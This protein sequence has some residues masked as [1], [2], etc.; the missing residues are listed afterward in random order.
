MDITD[1]VL[2]PEVPDTT[3]ATAPPAGNA[4]ASAGP[5]TNPIESGVH[6]EKKNRKKKKKKQHKK[7]H[8]KRVGS[9]ETELSKRATPPLLESFFGDGGGN[10]L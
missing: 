4:V 6:S 1:A 5:M 3:A 7:K 8:K 10:M 9:G 2:P